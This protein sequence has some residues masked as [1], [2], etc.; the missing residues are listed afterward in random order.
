MAGAA[1]QLAPEDLCR[2]HTIVY[3]EL[4]DIAALTAAFDPALSPP[5]D[6][7]RLRDGL[8]RF[9]GGDCGDSS[10][11]PTFRVRIQA[12]AKEVVSVLLGIDG[13]P[14]EVEGNMAA[15]VFLR[16]NKGKDPVLVEGAVRGLEPEDVLQW[17]TDGLREAAAP[18]S[19]D[20][21]S[22]VED[23]FTNS[24]FQRAFTRHGALLAYTY[25]TANDFIQALLRGFFASCSVDVARAVQQLNLGKLFPGF[26]GGSS[27]QGDAARS[28]LR[29]RCFG[30]LEEAMRGAGMLGEE[31][32]AAPSRLT[33][34]HLPAATHRCHLTAPAAMVGLPNL[35]MRAIGRATAHMAMA[36]CG[37]LYDIPQPTRAQLDVAVNGLRY[38][39]LRD[40]P[41]RSVSGDSGPEKYIEQHVA[42]YLNNLHACDDDVTVAS[43]NTPASAGHARALFS[44]GDSIWVLRSLFVH[45]AHGSGTFIP[46]F[47][48]WRKV[49]T[50][51]GSVKKWPTAISETKSIDVSIAGALPQY[52]VSAVAVLR[53]L[54]LVHGEGAAHLG[55]ILAGGCLQYFATYFDVDT[56]LFH[57]MPVRKVILLAG[58]ETPDAVRAAAR[59][60]VA[61]EEA[62]A[63][64]AR[65]QEKRLG[66]FGFLMKAAGEIDGEDG[67]DGDD[68]PNGDMPSWLSCRQ[69]MEFPELVR[70]ALGSCKPAALDVLRVVKSSFR[71][72]VLL[73]REQGDGTEVFAKLYERK[74]A[75][76]LAALALAEA[77]APGDVLHVLR[78]FP[79]SLGH[80]VVYSKVAP[81]PD[82]ASL[83]G[84]DKAA[85]AAQLEGLLATLHARDVFHGDVYE[86]NLSWD[87]S[88]HRLRLIDF[89]TARLLG[90]RD[91]ERAEWAFRDDDGLK[92]VRRALGIMQ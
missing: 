73:C 81:P 45:T 14:T 11:F 47:I 3:N 57:T 40:V 51:A 26:G 88:A 90:A 13:E 80:I 75:A 61:W 69:W 1:P 34:S 67:N 89:D 17:I 4:D 23:V 68:S 24:Q 36:P 53:S 71:T 9:F 64:V 33:F 16:N 92:H 49:V 55:R 72:V 35:V 42:A 59:E 21:Q 18:F 41:L 52:H 25:G 79:T 43:L 32:T 50:A 60:A 29:A 83:S 54:L 7:N 70:A 5:A 74:P 6:W 87:T 84:E 30:P 85:L 37:W 31:L 63:W 27:C 86:D 91:R 20:V 62:C 12:T 22:K 66:Y 8:R 48:R 2:R 78:D 46:D 10:A 39:E 15:A 77:A 44:S 19:V 82:I 65:Q 38:P 58:L 76:C 28:R 56:R